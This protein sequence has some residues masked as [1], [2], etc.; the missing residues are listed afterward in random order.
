[1]PFIGDCKDLG[2]GNI[3]LCG[4]APILHRDSD[5]FVARIRG[6][7]MN[8]WVTIKGLLLDKTPTSW[9]RRGSARSPSISTGWG[10]VATT[11][12]RAGVPSGW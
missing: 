2:V 8:V 7:G 3:R 5:K 9:L 6:R 1:M 10:R 4:G 12:S 11:T